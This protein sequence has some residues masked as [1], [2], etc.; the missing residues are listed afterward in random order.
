M[1]ILKEGVIVIDLFLKF[2]KWFAEQWEPV[3][4]FLRDNRNSP[5]LWIGLFL[6]GILIFKFTYDALSKNE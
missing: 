3:F 4:K 1:L 2:C 6:V 5:F